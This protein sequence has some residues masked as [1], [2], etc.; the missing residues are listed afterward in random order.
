MKSRLL[1]GAALVGAAAAPF[2][3]AAEDS[4]QSPSTVRQL[5]EDC[6]EPMK[7]LR[8]VGVISGVSGMMV[9]VGSLANGAETAEDRRLMFGLAACGE[10]TDE[11]AVQAFTSWA[12]KH[13]EHW[14]LEGRFGVVIA[15]NETWPCN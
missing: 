7:Q 8:C 3:V 11:T 1:L 4:G 13:P 2:S 14:G 15:L 12:E 9:L 10:W 5:Y 6:K